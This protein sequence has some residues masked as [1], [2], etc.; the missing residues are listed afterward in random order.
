MILGN[1]VSTT[2]INVSDD[3][4][5]VKSMD[6]IIHGLPTLIIGFDI[7]VKNFPN[8][9]VITRKADD[10]VYW[11][12][13]RTEKRDIFEEDVYNF[14]RLCYS[15]LVSNLTYYFI[16]P[17]FLTT[18]SI[19][20]II[21]KIHSLYNPVIYRYNDMVYIYGEKLIFGLDLSLLEF[22]G[23]NKDK[24]LLKLSKI[25]QVFL[26]ENQI[27]IEYKKRIENLDN[28]VKFIPYLYSIDHG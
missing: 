2:K 16:D 8:L 4:N 13:K 6:E 1:I 22:I 5:V 26:S 12:F 19:K 23:L 3:F 7:A 10:N 20:K 28:Q 25:G 11:T 24:I 27:F 9:D 18:K 17:F 21:K 15:S 14:T